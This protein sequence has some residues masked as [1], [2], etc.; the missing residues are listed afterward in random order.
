[1]G[2]RIPFRVPV[3]FAAAQDYIRLGF[4]ATIYL[5][6]VCQT[7]CFAFG[8]RGGR[9]Y[10]VEFNVRVCELLSLGL[11]LA[12]RWRRRKDAI[13]RSRRGPK[14][15]YVVLVVHSAG[16]C[17]T[18]CND[19]CCYQKRCDRF[20]KH[21]CKP[22]ASQTTSGSFFMLLSYLSLCWRT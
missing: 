6:E 21:G 4:F 14:C 9:A 15:S 19:R 22:A 16:L 5:Y 2:A 8:S 20:W 10:N 11:S 17:D 7:A 12:S 18:F 1:M 3:V 13:I